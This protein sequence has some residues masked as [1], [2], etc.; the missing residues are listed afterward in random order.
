MKRGIHCNTKD[1][2]DDDMMKDESGEVTLDG[3][4]T[5]FDT[6][7]V[8]RERVSEALKQG[9]HSSMEEYGKV[10]NPKTTKRLK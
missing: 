6:K 7:T 8:F 10:R 2:V 1:T 4:M 3:V 9:I 5:K